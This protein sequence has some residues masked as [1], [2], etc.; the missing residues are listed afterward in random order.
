MSAPHARGPTAEEV[1][2]R[3]S[4][5]HRL[6]ARTKIVGLVGL[7]VVSATTPPGRW[8]AFALYLALLATLAAIARLPLRFV[9]TRLTVEIPFLVAAAA[10]VFVADDGLRSGLTVALKITVGVLAI[11]VLSGTTSFPKVLQGFER[12]R[13]PRVIVLTVGFMWRSLHLIVDD[14]RRA[15]LARAARGYDPRWLWQAG[16]IARG[17]AALFVRSVERGERVYLAMLAR[18]YTGGVPATA[19]TP[20]VLRRADVAA[21][22]LFGGAVAGARVLA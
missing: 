10:L 18:G 5:V 19:V 12:L 9:L 20:S 17:M 14:A 4:P 1:A 13:T 11:V 6:D 3:S 16:P 2:A 7:A 21:G 8:G 15:R 22:L